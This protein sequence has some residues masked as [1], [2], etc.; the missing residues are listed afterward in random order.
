MI[1][2]LL[3]LFPYF[4]IYAMLAVEL[5]FVGERFSRIL[6]PILVLLV[7]APFHL[8]I[9]HFGN[10][11]TESATF[12]PKTG[13]RIL[14]T[15][16]QFVEEV[17]QRFEWTGYSLMGVFY[18]TALCLTWRVPFLAPLLP[19]TMLFLYDVVAYQPFSN[20]IQSSEAKVWLEDF[21][22]NTAFLVHSLLLSLSFLGYALPSL[23]KHLKDMM[24][25]VLRREIE[26][27][28]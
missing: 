12:S 1:F 27:R 9:A 10:F 21:V 11:A 18:I 22:T 7:V 16:P 25:D 6:S 26:P 3:Y 14:E 28:A 24:P 13:E 5:F 19:L 23:Q 4:F 8:H 2:F 15:P 20:A 17:V